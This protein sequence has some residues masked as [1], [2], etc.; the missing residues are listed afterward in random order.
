MAF[1]RQG[2]IAKIKA[3]FPYQTSSPTPNEKYPNSSRAG[4]HSPRGSD[5]RIGERPVPH[6]RLA[7][8]MTHLDD[9][10]LSAH[11]STRLG[12]DE[13]WCRRDPL[14]NMTEGAFPRLLV[15]I[16]MSLHRS[17]NDEV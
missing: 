13:R 7:R 9:A 2:L 8:S 14:R 1:S 6:A 12:P 10:M 5:N 3:F 17:A 4:R 16:E 11:R 15:G